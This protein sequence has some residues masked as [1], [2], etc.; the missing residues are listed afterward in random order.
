MYSNTEITLALRNPC[1]YTCAYCIGQ[2]QH[3]DVILHDLNKLEQ[4]YTDIKPFILTVFECKTG[5]PTLHPQIK[6][7]LRLCRAYGTISMPT[8]NSIKPS[9]WLDKAYA[10]GLL[11]NITLHP[12]A[13]SDLKAFIDRLKAMQDFGVTRINLGYIARP[14]RMEQLKA[15]QDNFELA[16]FKLRGVPFS[17]DWNGIKYPNGYTVE[18]K[19]LLGINES[20]Y[21]LT[22]LSMVMERNFKG[23]P[24]LAGKTLFC[25]SPETKLT[26]CLYDQAEISSPYTQPQPCRVDF[27]GCYLL[28]EALNNQTT[29]YWNHVRRI[30]GYPLLPTNNKTDEQLYLEAYQTYLNLMQQYG[31]LP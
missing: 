15:L 29:Q 18:D 22:R 20:T 12:S 6:D 4:I 27:C 5:E 7:I 31:K 17:G 11:L 8:N 3:Q 25:V 26:R 28:L 10:S 21:W 30:G 16:G 23:I 14:D 1:N 9:S 2:H 19:V 13:E 24:C